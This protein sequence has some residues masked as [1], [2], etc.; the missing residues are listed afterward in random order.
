MTP[1][2]YIKDGPQKPDDLIGKGKTIAKVF[3]AKVKSGVTDPIVL[4][5]YGPPGIGKSAT[6]KIIAKFVAGH[7]SGIR[8]LSA[9]QVT[10]EHIRDWMNEMN[11]ISDQWKVFWIEEVDAVNPTVQILLLQL[12]DILPKKVA[13]LFTSNEQMSGISTRFQSRAQVMRFEAPKVAEVS[14]FLLK[15]WP[16]LGKVAHEIA[17]TNNGDVRA[18]L[19]DAQTEIDIQ[20]Y[21]KN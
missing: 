10:A 8:H 14:K 20:K 2:E 5:C 17:E 9:A 18:S 16:E 4:Y 13:F 15:H 1:K 11:Y 7:S 19:N 21:S 6:C 12:L 3:C